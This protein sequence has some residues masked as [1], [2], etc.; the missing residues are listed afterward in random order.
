MKKNANRCQKQYGE[1]LG[2]KKKRHKFNINDTV[3][4]ATYKKQFRKSYADKKFTDGIFLI[5]DRYQPPNM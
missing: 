4:I 2:A 5:A 3:T 1:Y